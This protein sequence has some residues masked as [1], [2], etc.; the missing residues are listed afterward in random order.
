MNR[1]IVRIYILLFII[2]Y[3]QFPQKLVA[4]NSQIENNLYLIKDDISG[5]YGGVDIYNEVI[6]P[7][8]YDNLYARPYTKIISLHKYH[9]I[10]A[11][12]MDNLA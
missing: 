5:K 12:K 8:E 9:R 11:E 7:F 3:I 2:S 1:Q 10:I 6:I 4:Q